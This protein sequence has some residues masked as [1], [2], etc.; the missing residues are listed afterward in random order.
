MLE[1]LMLTCA[2][3]RELAF[4][5]AQIQLHQHTSPVPHRSRP[6]VVWAR[7]DSALRPAAIRT[8]RS[9]RDLTRSQAATVTRTR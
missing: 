3:L 1:A 9:P 8:H 5:R 7:A 6:S 2:W 4:Q